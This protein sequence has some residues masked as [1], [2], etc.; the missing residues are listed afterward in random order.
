MCCEGGRRDNLPVDHGREL[1]RSRCREGLDQFHGA[2]DVPLAT[3]MLAGMDGPTTPQRGKEA[4]LNSLV[5]SR[6]EGVELT[7]CLGVGR[8]AGHDGG[9]ARWVEDNG[10]PQTTRLDSLPKEGSGQKSAVAVQDDVS[11][12]NFRQLM[13]LA[14]SRLVDIEDERMQNMV[15][16]SPNPSDDI[17]PLPLPLQ[18]RDRSELASADLIFGLNLFACG[19]GDG[20][21]PNRELDGIVENLC[22]ICERFKVWDEP[23]G[24][25]DF[26][27][28]FAKRG[29]TYDGEEV[30]VA[31]TLTWEGVRNS[32]PDEVGRLELRDFCTQGTLHYLDHFEDHLIDTSNLPCPRAPRVMVGDDWPSICEGLIKKQICEVVPLDELFHIDQVPLLNGMF[33]V[34]KGE[35]VG[36]VETQRL[37]M[38]LVPL[39]GL[40]EPLVGDV[41]TLPNISSFGTF[42]LDEG[43]VALISSED[44]RCFFYLFKI[45]PAWKKFLG[46]NR[47]VPPE[48]VP[49]AWRGRPCVL[50]ACVLP[51]GFIN[52]VSIAQHVHRNIVRWSQQVEGGLSQGSEMRKDRVG[53]SAKAQYRV[54]LD[55]FD[56]VERLDP[57]TAATVEGQVAKSVE[58]LREQYAK[59]GIP[60]HPKKAVVRSQV[61]EIQGAIVDGAAGFAQP[62]ASK[63]ILYCHLALMLVQQEGCTLK[64]L[65]VVCGG[66]VYFAMFRRPL[67]S[68]LNEVWRFMEKLKRVPPVVRLPVPPGVKRE[69]LTFILLSPL[70]QIEFRCPFMDHVTCSD[71]STTGGGICVSEGLTGYGV[72]ALHTEGRGDLPQEGDTLQIF[73]VGLFDGLG[74]LRLAVDSL[75]IGVAGHLSVEKENT[76]RRVV[77]AFF[78]DTIFHEDV[79][80]VDAELVK[81]LA[82]RFPSVAMI[83]IGAGPP[84][85]GVSGLNASKKGALRDARSNLFQEV[86]RIRDLF[87]EAFPWAQVHLLMESVASMSET[88][89]VLMSE[90]VETIP[91]KIDSGGISLCHRPRLYWVDWDLREGEGVSIS[92]PVKGAQVWTGCGTVE[93]QAQVDATAFLEQGWFVTEGYKLPTFT[94][95][96]PREQPG[97]RPA[98]LERCA[99]HERQRWVDDRYRFPPYQ[100]RDHNL[101]WTTKG[102]SRRPTAQEREAIM[103]IPVGY[104][105]PCLPKAQ[106]GT[107]EWDDTRLTLIGNSWHVGVITWLL[108]QLLAPLGFC[109]QRS[110]QDI[111]NYL[112]PGKC[113]TLQGILLR[114]PLLSSKMLVATLEAPLLLKLLGLVSMKGEDLMVTAV[115]EPQVKFHRLRSSVPA[116]LWRWKEVTGW[117]WRHSGEHINVLELRAILTTLRWLVV[118]R[119]G[120]SKRFLHLTDS[121]VCLHSL[122]RGRSSSRKLRHV[123]TRVNSLILAADLHPIWGYVHTAQNPA[124]R[125]SRRPLG[126][127]WGK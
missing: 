86:P 34:G 125:P 105:R 72:A 115:S 84:C 113:S 45:P 118:R 35:F 79:Q 80:T 14:R 75:G 51:M 123:L 99:A 82:L 60:R 98:G 101:L 18:P 40:C 33:G 88:D 111:V 69:L 119:R 66:F 122:S 43:E 90:A 16:D 112:T 92:P 121:L 52:S 56:L 64:E 55:N 83:L 54:Y 77:E 39:N 5:D 67:L 57:A 11:L 93:L 47:Q 59:Q 110:L 95:S 12:E 78:P 17:F 116:K 61:A 8:V 41:C 31:Q 24:K 103:G 48:L 26:R 104:T 37:I 108:E 126:R 36:E 25:L 2:V 53:S 107:V 1:K 15:E 81:G 6:A 127:K 114:P 29:V 106:Q 109:R 3:S 97:Y 117:R 65:Q 19:R 46:F 28:F 63:V 68:A 96:R 71:A 94:T 62:K 76:G 102:K 50:T 4:E 91:Y 9:P 30:R 85:Q 23:L 32:L 13:S 124:D 87:K 21:R 42:L 20:P 7:G 27:D 120:Y 89:R 73:T 49:E 38:N 58:D 22:G 100:Y 70:A 44:I 74:A 10:S